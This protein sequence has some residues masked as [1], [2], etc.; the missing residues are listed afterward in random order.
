MNPLA[1]DPSDAS[2]PAARDG[3]PIGEPS[4]LQEGRVCTWCKRPIRPGV[5][6]DAKF[7]GQKDDWLI[8]RGVA[9]DPARSG[10][11]SPSGPPRNPAMLSQ[12]P[13]QA[14]P[15]C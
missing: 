1:V 12:Q 7:C 3:L 10:C 4:L 15:A 9:A 11:P 2:L 6:S 5:R 8:S 13:A 14:G